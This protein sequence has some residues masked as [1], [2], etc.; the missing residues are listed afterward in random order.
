MR[1]TYTCPIAILWWAIVLA[2]SRSRQAQKTQRLYYAIPI[3]A[4]LIIAAAFVVAYVLPPPNDVVMSFD[5]ALEIQVANNRTSSRLV[6]PPIVGVPGYTWATHTFDLY[7]AGGRY[8]LYTDAPT[9]NSNPF[10]V[11]HVRSRAVVN[12]TLGD[13]FSVWG[14]PLGPSQT[15]SCCP[16]DSTNTFWQMCVGL[17]GNPPSGLGKWEAEVL[18][19]NKIMVLVYYYAGGTGCL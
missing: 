9:G 12:Y 1:K 8:P 10:S 16:A 14:Q 13:F 15:L 11:I 18:T 5:V 7:G 17:L 4:V 6:S 3:I 2:R 19:P